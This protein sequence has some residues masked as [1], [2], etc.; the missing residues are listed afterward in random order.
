MDETWKKSVDDRLTGVDN[1][2]TGLEKEVHGIK[3][4]LDWMKVAFSLLIAV[5]GLVAGGMW[6]LYGK[7]DAISS[8]LS[9]EF[10]A[11]RAEMSAQTSAIAN[12]I[13]ATRQQA[14]QVILMPA[15]AQDA[16]RK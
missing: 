16:P 12:A 8:K 15:P 9:D 1:R 14:P 13:T 5:V 7:V 6:I 2:L 10:R 4:S 11:Q 3:G